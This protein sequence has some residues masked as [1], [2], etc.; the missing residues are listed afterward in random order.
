[1]VTA[2][3]RLCCLPP[4][5]KLRTIF[6]VKKLFDYMVAQDDPDYATVARISEPC[7]RTL[8]SDQTG[9]RMVLQVMAASVDGWHRPV[10]DVYVKS[11]NAFSRRRN[12]RTDAAVQKRAGSWRI[13][14][15][16][17][18]TKRSFCG[19]RR[20]R[21]LASRT[22]PQILQAARYHE[23]R[24][25]FHRRI[26]GIIG[27][28]CWPVATCAVL[29]PS[30]RSGSVCWGIFIRIIDCAGRLDEFQTFDDSQENVYASSVASHRVDEIPAAGGST[31]YRGM[32]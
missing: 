7:N 15:T 14:L 3:S 31:S 17:S 5:N 18:Y 11:S 2:L 13:S 1:M 10:S 26:D 24:P 25:Q 30:D 29:A 22:T 27:C 12:C 9:F 19:T 8:G 21:T 32:D 16:R 23:L 6:S 20:A 28:T 4:S